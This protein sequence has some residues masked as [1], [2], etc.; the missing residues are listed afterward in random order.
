M[1]L[2]ESICHQ[3]AKEKR[4]KTIYQLRYCYCKTTAKSHKETNLPICRWGYKKFKKLH[5]TM[6]SL[7]VK[8][9]Q[10]L[11][12]VPDLIMNQLRF[13]PHGY[14]F[15]FDRRMYLASQSFLWNPMQALE[16]FPLFVDLWLLCSAKMPGQYVERITSTR[17]DKRRDYDPLYY[18]YFFTD[19]FFLIH[20]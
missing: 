19:W 11:V 5:H 16:I 13:S 15:S 2:F 7:K 10:K 8:D 4:S 14:H 3:A 12:S 17:R 9:T 18:V 1:T 20:I 6:K